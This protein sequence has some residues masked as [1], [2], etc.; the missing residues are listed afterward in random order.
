LGVTDAVEVMPVMGSNTTAGGWQSLNEIH[1]QG[2]MTSDREVRR[3]VPRLA[4]QVP[5][6]EAGTIEMLPDGRMKTVY[7]LRRDVLWHDGAPFTAK[8]LVFSWELNTDR[9]LPRLSQD[10]LNQMES[11]EAPDDYTFVVFWKGPYYKA[12]SLG[13][14]A[15]WP[16][17]RHILEGPY[18]ALDPQTLT[19]HPYWTS[20][21]YVHLGPFR[22]VEFRNGEE[23][24]FDA[25]PGYFLGRPKAD[26]IIVRVFND[27]NVLFAAVKA[28]V[29][30][31]FA[32]NALQTELAFQL[33]EEWDRSGEGTVHVGM[34]T[35]RFIAP[36]FD[37]QLL[38]QPA[39]LDPRVRQALMLAIDRP[40][41]AEALK[42]GHREL[43]ADSLLPPVDA[44]YPA[45]KDGWARYTFDPERAKAMLAQL[46]WTPGS[47]GVLAGAGGQRLTV[48]LWTTQ[49]GESEI[50]I[51][52]DYWKRVGLSVEQ[53]EIPGVRVRNRE[54]RQSYPGFE[55]TA[56]G[57]GDSIVNRVDSRLSARAPDYSGTNRGH[58]VNP[59][60]DPLID[61]YRQSVDQ[62]ERERLIK[63]ISD[64]VVEDLPIMLLYFNPTHPGVRKG[65]KAFDDFKGGA[66]GSRL[67]G[68]FSR[69]AHEWDVL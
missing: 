25:Y 63:A 53:Y 28:G 69:N 12:N 7:P 14:R 52:A 47:D 17:P 22:L 41:L 15:Y 6:L 64:L 2:L 4:A 44:L 33:K 50:A 38:Q 36:Q 48:P 20:H 10:A 39:V 66:E 43:V 11:V 16:H 3:P 27:S 37:P 60:V 42:R 68:T 58:Y 61:Q 19:N 21:E 56:A 13:L 40:A 30:D 9:N 65:I 35:T 5:S 46:G 62:R 24:V 8:D 59:R 51:I 29:V 34:G 31:I 55:T 54:F 49:G 67:Y 1:A 45:V 18:R 23:L 32:D 26:R 57:Y